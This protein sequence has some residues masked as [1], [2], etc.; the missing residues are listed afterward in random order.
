MSAQGDVPPLQCP[1]CGSDDIDVNIVGTV[2]FSGNSWSLAWFSMD[3]TGE[4][5][6]YDCDHSSASKD[7]VKE[8]APA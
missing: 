8:A 4:A 3:E 6:C 7:F 2:R 5:T 1:K